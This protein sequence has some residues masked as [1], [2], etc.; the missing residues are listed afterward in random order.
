MW[1][2]ANSYNGWIIKCLNFSKGLHYSTVD[3]FVKLLCKNKTLVFIISAYFKPN[4]IN[5]TDD[6]NKALTKT[7][8]TEINLKQ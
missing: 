5:G 2:L 6:Q 3:Q 8:S 4:I 7:I 1:F